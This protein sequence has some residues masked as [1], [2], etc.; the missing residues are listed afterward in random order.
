[1]AFDDSTKIQPHE[2][3]DFV[4]TWPLPPGPKCVWRPDREQRQWFERHDPG[5][6]YMEPSGRMTDAWHRERAD[7]WRTRGFPP[8]DTRRIYF[9][10]PGGARNQP[11][12][13]D[14]RRALGPEMWGE[15]NR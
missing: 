6:R 9:C 8:E 12:E 13:P 1:M 10:P 4:F 3:P 2:L 7:R 11:P 15:E 14:P 5:A